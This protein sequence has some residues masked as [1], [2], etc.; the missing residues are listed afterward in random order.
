[1]EFQKTFEIETTSDRT[2]LEKITDLGLWDFFKAFVCSL[3]MSHNVILRCGAG[4]IE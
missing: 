3:N 1:M 2:K 4:E